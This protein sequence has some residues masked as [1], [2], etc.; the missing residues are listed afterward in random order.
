MKEQPNYDASNSKNQAYEKPAKRH[1]PKAIG[2]IEWH[3]LHAFFILLLREEGIRLAAVTSRSVFQTAM[4]FFTRIHECD[5]VCMDVFKQRAT[6]VG[7]SHL[8]IGMKRSTKTRVVE[9]FVVQA[10]SR[11]GPPS[12]FCG[13]AEV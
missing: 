13:V 4:G 9:N 6:I 5:L 1:I 3:R 12:Q 11:G 10:D 7:V 8:P 2:A